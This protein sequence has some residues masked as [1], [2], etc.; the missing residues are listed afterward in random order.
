MA[1]VTFKGVEVHTLGSLPALGSLAPGFALTTQDL[2]T[3]TLSNFK[4]KIVV[5]NIFMSLDTS[6][7]AT[8]VRTFNKAAADLENTI[9]VCISKDLPYAQRRFCATEGIENLVT[10]A[11]FR[12][13]N[14]GDA[15]KTLILD[16]PLEGLHT[17]CVVVIDKEGYVRYTEQVPEIV[18]EPDYRSALKAASEL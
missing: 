15:Y 18:K 9:V 3:V 2:K 6:T 1:V 10:L 14:F 8:S 5:L 13:D 11:D 17:R 16:G 4:G 7:C 12:N